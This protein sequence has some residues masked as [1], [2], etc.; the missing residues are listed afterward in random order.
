MFL[1]T[2]QERVASGATALDNL[3]PDWATKINLSVFKIEDTMN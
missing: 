1:S 3:D 2:P